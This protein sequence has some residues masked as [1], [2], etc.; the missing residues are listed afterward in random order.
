MIY[1]LKND[2]NNIT[3]KSPS[4]IARQNVGIIYADVVKTMKLVFRK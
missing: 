4:D 1:A 2:K 3:G